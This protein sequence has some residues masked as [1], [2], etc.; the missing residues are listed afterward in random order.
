M[1]LKMEDEEEMPTAER[2]HLF[3]EDILFE[4]V[5]NDTDAI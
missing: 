3:G 5:Q 2:E 4:E 1:D